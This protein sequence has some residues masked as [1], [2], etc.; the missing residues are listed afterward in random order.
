[1]QLQFKVST[2]A[3]IS[4][5]TGLFKAY[6]ILQISSATAV[7]WYN[8]V[9]DICAEYFLAH[10]AVIGGPGLKLKSMKV[11]LG[12]ASTTVAE[13]WMDTGCLLGLREA[14]ESAFGGG[15]EERCCNLASP[16]LPTCETGKYSTE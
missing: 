14:A 10:P 6:C 1:M 16:Y 9:H 11:N 7:D 2:Y 4:N 8:F 3:L 12:R 5:K 15:G 13:L